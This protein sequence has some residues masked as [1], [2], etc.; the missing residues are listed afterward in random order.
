MS[1]AAPNERVITAHRNTFRAV[2]LAGLRAS[3]C[4]GVRASTYLTLYSEWKSEGCR[5]VLHCRGWGNGSVA[6][7]GCSVLNCSTKRTMRFSKASFS[8]VSSSSEAPERSGLLH[9]SARV[10]ATPIVAVQHSVVKIKPLRKDS[11]WT[12]LTKASDAAAL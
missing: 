6:S 1:L 3:G 2:Y 8:G 9:W 7:C 5:V 4:P 10:R 11:L 12:N